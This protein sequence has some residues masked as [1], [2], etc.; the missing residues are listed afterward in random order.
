ME[1]TS[2]VQYVGIEHVERLNGRGLVLSSRPRKVKVPLPAHRPNYLSNGKGDRTSVILSS[3]S[4]TSTPASATEVENIKQRCL[5]WQWKGQYSINYFVSSEQ[6]HA[7]HP[8]L[9][10]VH[11]FGASLPHWRRNIKTLAQNY[12]VYAID[13]LGFGA[14]DKPPG[15]QYTM[16]TWSQLILD[17]LNEVI[18]KPTVLIGNSVG[19]LACVIAAAGMFDWSLSGCRCKLNFCQTV[20]H[21]EFVSETPVLPYL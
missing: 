18:Q 6:L 19:S 12:T 2:A 5:T 16:E 1:V 3:T 7:N 11:G 21:I 4:T 8:P 14:S 10:L 13:L 15:F 9:L 20:K 17:F